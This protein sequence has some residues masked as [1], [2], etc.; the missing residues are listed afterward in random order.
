MSLIQSEDLASL[1]KVFESMNDK[2]HEFHDELSSVNSQFVL[3][4]FSTSLAG[5][6]STNSAVTQESSKKFGQYD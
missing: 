2:F 5:D 4:A 1:T 3:I 6:R